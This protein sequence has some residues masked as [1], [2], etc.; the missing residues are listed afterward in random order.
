MS[1][2]LES[3]LQKFQSFFEKLRNGIRKRNLSTV[4]VNKEVKDI[5]H[6]TIE[7]KKEVKNIVVTIV[8]IKEE[9]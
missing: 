4:G 6:F 2:P 9:I 1:H 7:G 5:D 3:A 8:D